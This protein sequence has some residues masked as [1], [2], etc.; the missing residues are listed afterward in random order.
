MS[1]FYQKQIDAAEKILMNFKNGSNYDMLYAQMQSGKTGVSLYLAYRMLQEKMIEKVFII[2]GSSEKQLKK[3]WERKINDHKVDFYRKNL[4][5]F[6]TG[7]AEVLSNIEVIWRQDLLKNKHKFSKNYLVIWDESHF[8]TTKKQTLHK[9]F[10]E[11]GIIDGVQNNS[12]VLK[13]KNIYISSVTATRCAEQSRAVYHDT[14]F[15]TTIMEPG[16]DYRGLHYFYENDLVKDSYKFE[17]KNM[18]KITQIIESHMSQKKFLLARVSQNNMST[19]KR[20]CDM[21]KEICENMGIPFVEFVADTQDELSH[22]FD[23]APPCFTI[24]RIA[25]LFRMGKE[26]NKEHLCA[27]YESSSTNHNTLAQGFLGRTCGYHNYN[28]TIYLPE[29][30][31]KQGY[32]EYM[33]IVD[34][35]HSTGM[36]KT[37]HIGS[38]RFTTDNNG[39]I[40]Q[41][42]SGDEMPWPDNN[43]KEV[44]DNMMKEYIKANYDMS[45]IEDPGQREI[46]EKALDAPYEKGQNTN[47]TFQK[48]HNSSGDVQHSH[49]NDNT[50]ETHIRN[51]TRLN[52]KKKNHIVCYKIICL[53]GLT[54]EDLYKVGD[55]IVMCYTGNVGPAFDGP[56]IMESDKKNDL[57][58]TNEETEKD[59]NAGQTS[60]LKKETYDNPG[61]MKL[62][63]E[64]FIRNSLEKQDIVDVSKSVKSNK[65]GKNKNYIYL[66]KDAYPNVLNTIKRELEGQFGVK[67]NVEMVTRGRKPANCDDLRVKSI[68]WK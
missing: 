2:S 44:A 40:P 24:V 19:E 1:T 64:K 42:L 48:S 18:N 16:K 32:K 59:E 25:G 6:L 9:F 12:G 67:I 3:Q 53:T 4:E 66:N 68:S 29:K 15:T 35:G 55:I 50:I 11:I 30:Y 23:T 58:H 62:S 63:L 31:N 14:G 43:E 26:V 33:D 17:R 61:L 47:I 38:R 37:L 39:T 41:V 21:L 60:S 27:V 10:T 7:D 34:S 8:A 57:W 51:E 52:R 20:G 22:L 45:K 56:K 5:W 49:E 54:G 65:Y 36:S 28:V 13:Q 46:I